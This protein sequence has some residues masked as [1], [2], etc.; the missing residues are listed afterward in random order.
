MSFQ[1]WYIPLIVMAVVVLPPTIY[2]VVMWARANNPD[3]ETQAKLDVRAR[4]ARSP[5]GRENRE[6]RRVRL[7]AAL[8][9][10]LLIVCFVAI[11]PA[12]TSIVATAAS[13]ASTVVS[14]ALTVESFLTLQRIR[15]QQLPGPS[16]PDVPQPD[17]T[18]PGS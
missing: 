8:T 4:K 18:S 1:L 7:L 17:G 13:A 3:P 15:S 5:K 6:L 11:G 2:S 12:A 9:L 14:A 16:A 10:V